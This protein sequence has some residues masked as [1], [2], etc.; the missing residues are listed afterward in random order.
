MQR[1]RALHQRRN[2]V[3]SGKSDPDT[4]QSDL[5]I[6]EGKEAGKLAIERQSHRFHFG[7]IRTNPVAKY[8]IRG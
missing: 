8:V 1:L 7:T 2:A 6:E 4:V 5:L 3:V